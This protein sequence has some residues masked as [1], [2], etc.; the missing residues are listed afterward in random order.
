MYRPGSQIDGGTW[1]AWS[2]HVLSCL[3]RN[4]QVDEPV[5]QVLAVVRAGRP[6]L[7]AH[8]EP[9][10]RD[11]VEREVDDHR[12]HHVGDVERAREA[13]LELRER[14]LHLDEDRV[15]LLELLQAADDVGRHLPQLGAHVEHLEGLRQPI[16][17]VRQH[18]AALDSLDWPPPPPP[19][20]PPESVTMLSKSTAACV[21]SS[22]IC[23]LGCRPNW[24]GDSAGS[25]SSMYAA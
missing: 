2:D 3:T 6:N 20:P 25:F 5:A 7:A 19:E 22:E 17:D 8:L 21:C 16:L 4:E 14:A 13:E 15:G 12:V 24:I 18:V 9:Q 11:L 1:S 23:E 10:R